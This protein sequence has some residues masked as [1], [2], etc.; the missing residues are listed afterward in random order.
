MAHTCFECVKVHNVLKAM[1]ADLGGVVTV[2]PEFFTP[3]AELEHSYHSYPFTLTITV[4]SGKIFYN[5]EAVDGMNWFYPESFDGDEVNDFM[6]GLEMVYDHL[7][8][9]LNGGEWQHW[10]DGYLMTVREIREKMMA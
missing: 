5:M 4:G 10:Q 6:S 8:K 7:N 2:P 1:A 9:K 3:W